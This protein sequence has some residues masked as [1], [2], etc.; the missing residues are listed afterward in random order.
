MVVDFIY[1]DVTMQYQR[2]FNSKFIKDR[3][4]LFDISLGLMPRFFDASDAL[5]K[6]L[7][8]EDQ[9]VPEMYFI[10][11]GLIGFA[12]NSFFQKMGGLFYKIGRKQEGRQ[13]ICDHYVVNKKKSKFI[14]MALED[15]EALAIS[16]KYMQNVIFAKY[17]EYEGDIKS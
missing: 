7:Y 13:L 11:K 4:F 3:K 9:E 2:F 8:E 14:Y 17:S 1:R 16:R 10:T 12:V 5:D 15:V 6:V